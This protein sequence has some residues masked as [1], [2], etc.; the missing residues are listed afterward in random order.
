MATKMYR[1]AAL[2]LAAAWLVAG[3]AQAQQRSQVISPRPGLTTTLRLSQ[4]LHGKRIG[5]PSTTGKPSATF[6]AEEPQDRIEGQRK[7]Q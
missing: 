3:P 4:A 5:K 2:A 7:K 1:C 6:K